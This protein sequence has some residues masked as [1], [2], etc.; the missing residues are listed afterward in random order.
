[1]CDTRLIKGRTLL[2]DED[3][4]ELQTQN[5]LLNMLTHTTKVEAICG[6]IEEDASPIP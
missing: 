1:V 3:E 2:E 6:I 4:Q 5:N